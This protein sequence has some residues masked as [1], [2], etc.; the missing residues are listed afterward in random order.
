[1]CFITNFI[2][3]QL[4]SALK[5]YPILYNFKNFT[6]K[7]FKL[8]KKI[9][10]KCTRT[11]SNNSTNCFPVHITSV[12][13][14]IKNYIKYIF[15]GRLFTIIILVILRCI[16]RYKVSFITCHYWFVLYFL[17]PISGLVPYLTNNL[18]S[19]GLGTPYTLNTCSCVQ[20]WRTHELW[21]CTFVIYICDISISPKL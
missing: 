16:V 18:T 20:L 14:I 15:F 7:Y 19:H 6:K 10:Y 2:K 4:I 5:R 17:E 1:M 9:N 8:V 11:E 13:T 21:S 12:I 3:E